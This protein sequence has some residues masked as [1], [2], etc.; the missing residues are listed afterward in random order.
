MTVTINSLE[1]QLQC[2]L[3]FL[4]LGIVLEC[5]IQRQLE[6]KHLSLSIRTWDNSCVE[7]LCYRTQSSRDSASVPSA[8]SLNASGKNYVRRH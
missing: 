8:I 6:H 1:G 4:L 7:W 3:A 5:D 2:A